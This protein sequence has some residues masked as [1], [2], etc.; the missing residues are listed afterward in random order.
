MGTQ[1][2]PH[3]LTGVSLVLAPESW[4]GAASP[5]SELVG[6]PRCSMSQGRSGARSEDA[7]PVASMAFFTSSRRP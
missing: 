1:G 3:Q 6:A 5:A 2:A 7:S 4:L